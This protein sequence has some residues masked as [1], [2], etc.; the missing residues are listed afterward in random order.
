MTKQK[1][2][3]FS[4]IQPTG[5]IHIGNYLGALKNWVELQDK[6]QTI[7]SIVDWHAITVDQNPAKYK[8]RVLE[9]AVDLL[10]IGIDPKKSILFVQSQVVGHTEL[11]WIF[12]TLTPIAE[13]ERMTQYKDKAKQHKHNI[14]V[15]LFSYPVLQAADILL[16][17]ATVV[18][19]GED[20]L[21]HIELA[22]TVQRKFNNKYGSTFEPIK[23]LLTKGARI[24]SLTKPDKKMSKS[25]GESTYI[26]LRDKPDVIRKK[27]A[28]AV[29]DTGPVKI[30]KKSLGVHN[31][32]ELLHLFTNDKIVAKYEKQYNDNSIKYS[33][34][35]NELADAVIK[36]LEPIQKRIKELE[37][38]PKKVEAILAKGAKQAQAIADKNMLDIRK[39][40]GLLN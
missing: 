9:T 34:M 3:L 24:M 21:Q 26:A 28:K 40:L 29:T 32:F 25:L 15:G 7:Y 1:K 19:V 6:Y 12:N 2:I 39:K 31:L 4:G 18:P 37:I 16:Y 14:N 22:N 36:T 11:A 35:K 27:I 30:D 17:N 13:L 38:K 10:A 8:D 23:P 33:E 5:N 20:Q